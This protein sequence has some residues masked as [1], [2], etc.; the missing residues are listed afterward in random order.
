MSAQKWKMAEVAKKAMTSVAKLIG[1]PLSHRK[2]PEFSSD[3]VR[4]QPA[5]QRDM[6]L[7]S[8][9]RVGMLRMR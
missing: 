9:N 8:M 4:F 6:L 3:E 2:R 5:D 1:N 7:S